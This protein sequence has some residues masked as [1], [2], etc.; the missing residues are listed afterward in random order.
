[1]P[2]VRPRFHLT[3]CSKFRGHLRVTLAATTSRVSRLFKGRTYGLGYTGRATN[4]V[5][6]AALDPQQT[7]GFRRCA[8]AV[9]PWEIN[10]AAA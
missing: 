5:A 3:P 10:D 8:T 7:L 9:L 1:M 6:K 2:A 4:V